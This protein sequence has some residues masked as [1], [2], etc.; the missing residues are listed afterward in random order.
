MTKENH[1]R[2]LKGLTEEEKMYFY[3]LLI[4]EEWSYFVTLTCSRPA[5]LGE[6][7]IHLNNFERS[8]DG[9]IQNASNFFFSIVP[10][11][12]A[13]DDSEDDRFHVHGVIDR[14]RAPEQ[15]P[16]Q[17]QLKELWRSPRG[18]YYQKVSGL[19]RIGSF[20]LGRSEFEPFN[21]KEKG[22]WYILNQTRR[23]LVFSNLKNPELQELYPANRQSIS[24]ESLKHI[25]GTR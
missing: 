7:W 3:D 9:L 20:V 14:G 1:D 13:S 2:T 8:Y 11:P 4:Q 16:T 25:L 17:K 12:N 18:R 15:E 5:S 21:P 6:M 23:G 10:N 22:L 19:Y 24:L